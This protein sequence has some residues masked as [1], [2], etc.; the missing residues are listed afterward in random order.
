MALMNHRNPMTFTTTLRA[1]ITDPVPNEID[2]G[3]REHIVCGTGLV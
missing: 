2:A 1:H 3:N